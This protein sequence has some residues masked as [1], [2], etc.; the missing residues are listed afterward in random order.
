MYYPTTCIISVSIPHRFNSHRHL[1]CRD[2][3][4][5]KR[6]NPSQVQFTPRKTGL[7]DKAYR[8]FQSLT[9]S[10]H[11]GFSGWKYRKLLSVSI[12]HRF[13]SHPSWMTNTYPGDTSFNP[14]QVQFTHFVLV[15]WITVVVV[16]IPHRFNSHY[17]NIKL[18]EKMEMSFNPSQVQF[19]QGGD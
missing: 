2:F 19:T 6:F 5:F 18:R 16:S 14:S 8:M 15:I 11:T 9:G 12:P 1:R 13:N 4:L 7:K 10:I 3:F 17:T